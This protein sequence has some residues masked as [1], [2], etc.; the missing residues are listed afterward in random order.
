M[1]VDLVVLV[2]SSVVLALPFALLHHVNTIDGPAHVAGATLIGQE[3]NLAVVRRYFRIS[4]T[5][6]PNLVTPLA[7]SALMT[8]VSPT[9]AEKLL[10]IG[11]IVAFPLAVRFAIL[12]VSPR[13]GWLSLLSLPFVVNYMLLFGFYD[14]CWAMVG[15]MVAIGVALRARGRWKARHVVTLAV[16]LVLTYAT[17]L[18]PAVMAVGVILAL[19]L[20][21]ALS[22][23]GRGDPG[24]R[25][26][27]AAAALLPPTLA[28][29]SAVGLVAW[30]LQSG[31]G[32]GSAIV[33]KSLT[34]LVGGLATLTLPIVSYSPLEIVGALLTCALLLVLVA[35]AWR[36]VRRSTISPLTWRLTVVTAACTAV[37]FLA[38]DQVG[39]GSFLNDRLSLFPPLVL[40]LALASVVHHGRVLR[41]TGVAAAA[42]ALGMA[43]ARLPT[44]VRYDRLVDEYLSAAPAIPRGA[45]LVALRYHVFSPPLGDQ[46]YKQQDPL[47]NEANRLAAQRDAVDLRS[48]EA[49]VGYFLESF[50][51]PVEGPIAAD[52]NNFAVPPPVHL[53]A[54]DHSARHVDYVLIVGLRQASAAVRHAPATEAV[55]RELARHYV[56]VYATKPTGLVA[57]YRYR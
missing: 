27:G 51:P 39:T 53:A 9:W 17:H 47:D 55:E 32:G 34:S 38:P 40:L 56:E 18:V 19:A 57:V 48:L 21:E 46:R 50:R 2:L 29:L 12:S 16:V 25:R 20:T 15:A 41:L 24:G 31:D 13:A 52:L 22:W 23:R 10:V 42:V 35:A 30:Y 28:V 11:Y 37:Y 44:Q 4:Y 26:R 5:P 1:T 33:R 54:Y 14:F 8:V 7:L 6:V 36:A 45:T 3:R 49:E 43:G